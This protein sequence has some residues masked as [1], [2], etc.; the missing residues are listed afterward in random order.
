MNRRDFLKQVPSATVMVASAISNQLH[1][2]LLGSIREGAAMV[3]AAARANDWLVRWEKNILNSARSRYCDK[4]MGEE[5]GWLVSPILNGFY[6]GYLATH[7]S[8]WVELLIEWTDAGLKRG[9]TEPDGFVGWP[10]GDG[11]G[12][13][14]QE[15]SGDRPLGA[16]LKV[17]PT[18]L[19]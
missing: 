13:D 15:F 11:G 4:E 16:R 9:V 10:K 2:Q 14:S 1:C 17:R 8:K 3:P 18:R 6:Y 12:G 7:D 19:R 5:L